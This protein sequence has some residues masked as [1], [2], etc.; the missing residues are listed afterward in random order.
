MDTGGKRSAHILGAAGENGPEVR[1]FA[2]PSHRNAL[3]PGWPRS[4]K[5]VA[6]RDD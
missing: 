1:T 4:D 6:A 2:E 5:I 3:R